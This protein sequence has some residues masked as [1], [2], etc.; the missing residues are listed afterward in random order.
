MDFVIHKVNI[1]QIKLLHNVK[2]NLIYIFKK[3]LILKIKKME[4]KV[5]VIFFEMYNGNCF[6]FFSL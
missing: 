1:F 3:Y 4:I 5:I 6:L 2:K